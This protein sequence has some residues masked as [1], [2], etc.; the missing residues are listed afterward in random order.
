MPIIISVIWQ[1]DMLVSLDHSIWFHAPYNAADWH[2]FV[3]DSPIAT[4]GRALCHGKFF[5]RDGTLVLSIVCESIVLIIAQV[6][7]LI[8]QAQEVVIRAHL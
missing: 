4:G 2:L 5:S 8:A 1:V 6:G 3:M 7:A